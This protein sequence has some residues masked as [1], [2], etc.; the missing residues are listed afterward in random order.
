MIAR[1]LAEART[2]TQTWTLPPD[3]RVVKV[4]SALKSQNKL[5]EVWILVRSVENAEIED[6]G[7]SISTLIHQDDR[8]SWFHR[9]LARICRTVHQWRWEEF[10]STSSTS[11]GVVWELVELYPQPDKVPWFALFQWMAC[12]SHYRLATFCLLWSTGCHNLCAMIEIHHFKRMWH[13][14]IQGIRLHK[15]GLRPFH[16]EDSEWNEIAINRLITNLSSHEE[17][18]IFSMCNDL[19]AKYWVAN[20]P[21]LASTSLNLVIASIVF[22]DLVKL[23]LVVVMQR[24]NE[25][26]SDQEKFY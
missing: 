12:P 9:S 17:E 24:L 23:C 11:F 6:S 20:H 1:W 26:R 21:F 4:L 2:W 13:L 15:R 25:I 8:W 18:S 22:T 19:W 16:F 5:C 3:H 7:E 10:Q 14:R